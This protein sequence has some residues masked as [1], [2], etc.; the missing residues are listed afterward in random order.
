MAVGGSSFSQGKARRRNWR[1]KQTMQSR[2]P[3]RGNKASKPQ[4]VKTCGIVAVRETPR[5][6]GGFVGGTHR[7][8]EHTKTHPPRNQH[9]KGPI[10]LW[11][12][13]EVTESWQRAE[14]AALF[15]LGSSPT[16]SVTA[17]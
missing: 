1:A 2:V 10:C 17:Q 14:Q 4:A 3:V 8:L 9:Q 7:V 11:V 6:T 5:V 12:A 16:Y 13:G 15:P